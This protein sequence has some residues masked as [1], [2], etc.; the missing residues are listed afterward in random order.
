MKNLVNALTGKKAMYIVLAITV[1]CTILEI[2]TS[3]RIASYKVD[4]FAMGIIYSVIT[5]WATC[6]EKKENKKAEA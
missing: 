2:V 6:L 5:I 4:W 3:I 1:I